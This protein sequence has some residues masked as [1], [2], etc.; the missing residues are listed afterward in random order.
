MKKYISLVA[1]ALLAA[2]NGDEP[3]VPIV[4]DPL[5]ERTIVQGNLIGFLSDEGAHVWRSVPYAAA[6]EG[7]LRW[8]APRP[9]GGWDG[10]R[11]ATEFGD[12]CAQISNIFS[13][14]E[15]VPYGEIAGSEDCLLVDVYAPPMGEEAAINANLPVMVWIHGGSNVSGASKLYNG[16]I[17]AREQ[18]V[19][20]VSV[21]YRLG[22]LG[23]F[24]HDAIRNSAEIANDRSVNFGT[25]DLVASLDWVK[26]NAVK[27][28]GN[29][30]N[31]T[32]FG[33]S[34]GGHNVVTLLAAPQAKGLFHRAI[35]QSGS[36][37]SSTLTEAM[38]AESEL[39][40]PSAKVAERLG[41]TTA[42]AMRAASLQAV[43]D[44]FEL[45]EGGYMEMP[46]IIEDGV[47]IIDGSLR[48]IFTS[49][50]RFNNVPIIT[51]TN[52]DEMKL[53]QIANPQLV[54]R[55]FNVIVVAKDQ[56]VYDAA[57]EYTTRI[58]RLRS[59]DQPAA[60]MAAAG[61]EAV[62]G[63]RFDW[64]DGGKFLMTDFKKL[65]GAAH[66]MEIPFV[67]HHFELL[68]KQLDGILFKKNTLDD[69]NQLALE[70]GSYWASFARDGVPSSDEGSRAAW[71]QWN[72]N[73]GTL[74][75]FDAPSDGGTKSFA[76][77]ETFDGILSDLKGDQRVSDSERCQIGEFMIEWVPDQK[78]MVHQELGCS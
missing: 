57:S 63:Y 32:I 52:R 25:L 20:I 1:A 26:E 43:F 22:P 30:E 4:A 29:P 65:L 36:F 17:L 41:A 40:N 51:G 62:Y 15:D 56:D 61:H 16:A 54:K 8:R 23:W 75:R 68:G 38:S 12:R 14:S 58:W 45:D 42:E 21:Q 33:E 74:M 64:D 27:F 35:I 18:N 48:D 28:G 73:G 67:F 55:Y 76:D 13:Q 19:V 34:A 53:F 39:L 10:T 7:D 2:C 37:D 60:A 50:E 44:A 5:S 24:A 72:S 59:V 70:M 11:D 31:V 69:R 47:T 77:L 46:R 9:H 78:S 49:T 6:P 71:P 66:A 3:V